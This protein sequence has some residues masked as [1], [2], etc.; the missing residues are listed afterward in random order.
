MRYR[1]MRVW[2]AGSETGKKALRE[3]FWFM[4]FLMLCIILHICAFSLSDSNIQNILSG[5]AVMILLGPYTA[6]M[7]FMTYEAL[8]ALKENKLIILDLYDYYEFTKMK[9]IPENQFIVF[10]NDFGTVLGMKKDMKET[11][12]FTKGFRRY[13][14]FVKYYEKM[15]EG[16]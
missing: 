10:T 2:S 12:Y 14:Q 13:Y 11:L 8:N 3:F 15:K 5:I 16:R 9:D 6:L 7:L 1:R 4:L